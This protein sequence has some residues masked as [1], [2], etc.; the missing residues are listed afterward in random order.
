MKLPLDYQIKSYME[1]FK[2][3]VETK[4]GDQLIAFLDSCFEDVKLFVELSSIRL[5][6]TR[7]LFRASKR[8]DAQDMFNSFREL[9]LT[10]QASLIRVRGLIDKHQY[11]RKFDRLLFT[12]AEIVE[13]TTQRTIKSKIPSPEIDYLKVDGVTEFDVDWILQKMKNYWGK[14]LQLYGSLRIDIIL[15]PRY[16]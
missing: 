9:C 1:F 8:K 7:A 14:F 5:N 2:E 12:I 4:P 13:K 6:D 11:S 16:R 3:I 10:F 15:S